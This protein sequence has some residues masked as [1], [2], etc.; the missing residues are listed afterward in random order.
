MKFWSDFREFA[1]KRN[2]LD[3]AIGVVLG[4]AFQRIVDVLVNEI[5]MP[6][7]AWLSGNVDTGS[8]S[9]NIGPIPFGVGALINAVL[10][11]SLIALAVFLVVNALNGLQIRQAEKD[12]SEAP[13]DPSID[14]LTEIRD[15]LKN[16]PKK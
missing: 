4:A 9:V 2:A 13:S 8:W 5:L 14:L 11:F 16:D 3:L 6:P 1:L 10:Q 12:A 15:L 7:L